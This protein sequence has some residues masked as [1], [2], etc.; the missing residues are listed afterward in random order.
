MHKFCEI[1]LLLVLSVY[2]ILHV[3]HLILSPRPQK[4]FTDD[5]DVHNKTTKLKGKT[6]RDCVMHLHH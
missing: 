5:S 1:C 6:L 3:M 4:L 2:L